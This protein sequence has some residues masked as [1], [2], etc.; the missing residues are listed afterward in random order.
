MNKTTSLQLTL[1]IDEIKKLYQDLAD[2]NNFKFSSQISNLN[3]TN[4]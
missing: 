4:K 3:N 2:C 1:K